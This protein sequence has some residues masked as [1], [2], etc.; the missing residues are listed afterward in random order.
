MFRSDSNAVDFWHHFM[1][2]ICERDARINKSFNSDTIYDVFVALANLTRTKS[3]NTGPINQRELQESFEGVVGALPVENA[4]VMLQRLPSLGRVGPESSDRQFIGTYILDGLRAIGIK[5]YAESDEDSKKKAVAAR[6]TNSLGD[7]GQSIV[8]REAESK[9]RGFISLAERAAAAYNHVLASDI[10]ASMTRTSGEVIRFNNLVVAD[11]AITELDL[12]ECNAAG[13]TFLAC[14]MEELVLPTLPPTAI[15][16]DGCLISRVSGASS[17]S[18]LPAWIT[19]VSVE[20]Y[21]SV[22]TMRRIRDAGLE[23]A[24]EVLVV[25]VKKTFFQPGTGRK[26]EALTRGFEAGRHGKVFKKVLSI[27]TNSGILETFKGKEGT[28]YT[29]NRSETSRMQ[30]MLDELKSSQDPVWVAVSAL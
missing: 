24:S 18:G 8:A 9:P 15:K 27:L 25:I 13:L 11:S 3:A 30:A 1:R 4:S 19:N 16:I 20:E 12:S 14:T 10:A 2:V 29:P 7:L 26:E 23:A 28:V 5:R 17:E 22:R 6:W 21:D